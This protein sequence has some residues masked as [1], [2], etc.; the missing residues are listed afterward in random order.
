MRFRNVYRNK[1]LPVPT[2]I[3]WAS[4]DPL[5]SREQAY[6]LFKAIS[7]KQAATQMHVINRSGSF[8]FRER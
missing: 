7:E 8:A 2:Q 5:T 4:H 3:V 1:G 6:V